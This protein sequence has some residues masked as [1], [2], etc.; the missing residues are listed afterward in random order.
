MIPLRFMLGFIL[1]WFLMVVGCN[2]FSGLAMTTGIRAGLDPSSGASGVTTTYSTDTSGAPAQY[3][4]LSP[5]ALQTFQQWA[6]FD[7][8]ALWDDPD[9][10]KPDEFRSAIRY[11]MLIIV[12]IGFLIA[13]A[14][15][16]K[17]IFGL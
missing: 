9:T 5:T 8:P 13:L 12:G 3:Q 16:L 4:N 10:G 2:W 14:F 17:Q 6:F 1:M 11:G 15:T 7:Y